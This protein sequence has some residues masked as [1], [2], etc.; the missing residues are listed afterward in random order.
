M[1]QSSPLVMKHFMSL[2]YTAQSTAPS[3]PPFDDV[4]SYSAGFIREAGC[5]W[6]TS[7]SEPTESS[8]SASS[9][10]PLID[11]PRPSQLELYAIASTPSVWARK[12]A[13]APYLL[14]LQITSWRPLV[15]ARTS[16]VSRMVNRRCI[17]WSARS[18]ST[19]CVRKYLLISVS[20]RGSYTTGCTEFALIHSV[21]VAV[22]YARPVSVSEKP[23]ILET[24]LPSHDQTRT[25]RSK[26]PV[27]SQLF[28]GSNVTAEMAPSC[29]LTVVCVF[30]IIVAWVFFIGDSSET[31]ARPTR[32]RGSPC[33]SVRVVSHTRS[34]RS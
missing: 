1:V 20:V 31:A 4:L 9:V 29:E 24:R 19:D 3:C 22:A 27:M 17:R 30:F 2:Q 13:L 11:A 8:T 26:L 32:R 33:A 6:R 7:A 21:L 15:A 16:P 18:F 28:S 14:Y 23:S 12:I 10:T 25:E 34:V 5:H